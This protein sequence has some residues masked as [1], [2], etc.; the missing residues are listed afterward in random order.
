VAFASGSAA[1]GFVQLAG[2][3]VRAKI[4]CMGETCAA[5]ARAA[6]LHVDA[7]SDGGFRELCDTL[8]RAI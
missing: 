8:D 2:A 4:V 1:R 7:V 5:E 6:G 3:A